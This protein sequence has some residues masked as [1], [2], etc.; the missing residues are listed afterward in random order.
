MACN[1]E[2]FVCLRVLE[3]PSVQKKSVAVCI[4]QY[5]SIYCVLCNVVCPPLLFFLKEGVSVSPFV[6]SI[7]PMTSFRVPGLVF[8]CTC[9]TAK[10]NLTR[11][12]F[13]IDQPI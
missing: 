12:F 11:I 2:R 6:A 8:F 3:E 4:L 9:G 13:F 1:D 7:G 5:K 10:K